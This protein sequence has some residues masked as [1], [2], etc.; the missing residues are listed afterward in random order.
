[1]SELIPEK[2]VEMF[3]IASPLFTDYAEKQRLIKIPDGQKATIDGNGL[4]LF[5]D[6]TI[7]AKT[8]YYSKSG[9]K[10]RRMVETR[11]L[12][13]KHG[14]W[15]AATYQWN[16]MQTNA[17]LL[18]SGAVVPIAFEDHSGIQRKL[19][20]KIPS[21]NDCSSCH[22]SGDQLSPIGPKARNL[23]MTVTAEG[24]RQNQLDY[25]IKKGIFNPAD[26]IAIGALP[27]YKD[28]TLDVAMRARAYFDINCA[29]CHQPAG[30]A[31]Q[32]S[33]NLGYS[34]SF[35]ETGIGFNKQ[36][37]LIRM[38]TMGA[39]HMPKIGTTVLDDEGV[40]L[41]KTYI[42]GLDSHLNQ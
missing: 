39:Y 34:T 4:P 41:V 10:K 8:F 23:N 31:S 30:A 38:S 1:M 2:G 17:D 25:F 24:K 19:A 5:P 33:L 21:Q 14:K 11:L 9:N 7:I 13:L 36:N 3:D 28:T 42:K 40:Q 35:E 6:G 15:N 29:H 27:S 16:V 32:T 20:Y 26:L 18:T 22:R 37:I 12:I